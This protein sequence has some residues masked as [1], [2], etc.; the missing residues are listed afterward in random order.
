MSKIVVQY[1]AGLGEPVKERLHADVEYETGKDK[2]ERMRCVCH[3]QAWVIPNT[4]SAS[5]KHFHIFACPF[6]FGTSS[7]SLFTNIDHHPSSMS[8]AMLA[9]SDARLCD[10]F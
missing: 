4:R 5:G 1:F 6:R 8:L 2:I 7:A 3:R 9:M 10:M